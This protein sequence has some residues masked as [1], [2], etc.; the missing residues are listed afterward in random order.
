[1]GGG[2][3]KVVVGMVDATPM[4]YIGNVISSNGTVQMFF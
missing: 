4:D 3:E 2:S 1:M